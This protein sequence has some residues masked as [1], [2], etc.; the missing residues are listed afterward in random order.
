MFSLPPSHSIF[1]KRAFRPVL[2]H[3]RR[4]PSANRARRWSWRALFAFGSMD[5]LV[6][7]STTT[8]YVA[9]LGM[10]AVDVRTPRMAMDEEKCAGSPSPLPGSPAGLNG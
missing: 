1:Y 9:S 5:L 10:L 8:A 6:A 7:M 2:A 3:L 4:K